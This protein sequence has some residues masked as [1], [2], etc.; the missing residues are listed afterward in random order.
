MG[1]NQSKPA[2]KIHNLLDMPIWIF[3]TSPEINKEN[4]E[5]KVNNW[6][7]YFEK[8]GVKNRYFIHY[9]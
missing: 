2:T 9:T 4:N 6:K 7:N 5:K 3:N 8:N 1:S